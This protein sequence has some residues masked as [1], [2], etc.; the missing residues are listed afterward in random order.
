MVIM[1]ELDTY[2]EDDSYRQAKIRLGLFRIDN[3]VSSVN[4][5]F[6]N[7]ELEMPDI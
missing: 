2:R 6:R 4:K 1:D 5:F 7:H 3:V